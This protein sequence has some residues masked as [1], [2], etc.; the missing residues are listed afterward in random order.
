MIFD[1]Q[2]MFSDDQVVNANAPSTDVIDLGAAK[3]LGRGRPIP[4]RVQ[5]TADATGTTPTLQVDLETDD[6]EGFASA[7]VI[8]SANIAGGVAGDVFNFNYVPK[9]TERYI[10]L[11]FTVG[12]TTPVYQVTAG[13]VMEHQ[14]NP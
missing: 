1:L 9:G 11:N 2:T 13:L 12:G 8:Q 4:I 3:D 7:T 5:L 10:R 6:N 14:D